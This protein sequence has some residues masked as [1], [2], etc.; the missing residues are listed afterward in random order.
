MENIQFSLLTAL[1]GA[2]PANDA[3]QGAKALFA[4]TPDDAAGQ[5]QGF[6]SFIEGMLKTEPESG[7]EKADPLGGPLVF[8]AAPFALEAVREKLAAQG[9]SDVEPKGEI[10]FAAVPAA[11]GETPAS[12]AFSETPAND[13]LPAAP[14]AKAPAAQAALAGEA[15]LEPIADVAEGEAVADP[16]LQAEEAPIQGKKGVADAVAPVLPGAAKAP[17]NAGQ[18]TAAQATA[19]MAKTAK[20][21]GAA[22]EA[23]SPEPDLAPKLQRGK[24]ETALGHFSAQHD[25]LKARGLVTN[26]HANAVSAITEYAAPEALAHSAVTR[27][28]DGADLDQ[29]S[30]TRLETV[31]ATDRNV[32][33]VRDQ[34]VAAVSARPGDNKIEIRLDPPELG[35]VTIGFEKDG[36][37]MVRAV[38][39]AESPDTLDLIRRHADVFQRAL[40]DQGFSGLDLHFSDRGPRENPADGSNGQTQH[41]R[42]TEEE[43]QAAA[44]GPAPEVALGRLDRRL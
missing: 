23:R 6:F 43:A 42:L 16:D 25:P 2:K 14:G 27:D 10:V 17:E 12:A 37:D 21:E 28:A 18:A 8:G 15:A 32:H 5:S 20:T 26:I 22:E 35:R 39:T 36:A 24:S 31:A 38:I 11:L 13:A 40:E 29:L 3:S 1:F 4:K 41:F 19:V 7:E 30:S 33:P 44:A 34:I 9:A